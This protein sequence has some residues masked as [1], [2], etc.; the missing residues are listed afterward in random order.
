MNWLA[1]LLLAK[2]DAENR[3][4]NLLGDL[5][6]G[7][8][9][10]NLPTQFQFGLQCHQLIDCYT[11]SH[12]IVERSKQR[13]RANYGRFSGVAIDIFYDHLLTQNWQN[14]SVVSLQDFITQVYSSFSDYLELIPP[15]ASS[16]ISRMIEEDW[17]T[18]YQTLSGIEYTLKRI[19]WRIR[20]KTKRNF[21]LSLAVNELQ[22][23]YN[24]FDR[25][26]QEFFPQLKTYIYNWNL[27][28]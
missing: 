21:D 17:L 22:Q 11:D 28:H 27:S 16:V 12:E 8:E 25:D 23:H 19:S 6:K 15:R 9:R 4:G 24:D 13:I 26:F 3:L 5:V 18:S 10:N 1:H 2:P 20:R 7:R 14:Y